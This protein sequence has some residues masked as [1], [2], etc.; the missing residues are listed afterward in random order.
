MRVAVPAA[1]V[2]LEVRPLL[3]D[4]ELRLSVVYWEGAVEAVGGGLTG[5]GYLELTG[6]RR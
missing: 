5:S 4:Q 1:G 2:R 3:Q 6:Y